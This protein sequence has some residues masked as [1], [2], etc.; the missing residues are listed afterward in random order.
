MIT[1][2]KNLYTFFFK[3]QNADKNFLAFFRLS[4]GAFCLLRFLAIRKDFSL[5]YSKEGVIP[6]EVGELYKIKFIPSISDFSDFL[7]NHLGFSEHNALLLFQC[8]YIAAAVFVIIGFIS[9]G[10]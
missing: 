2:M 5:L 7:N 4:I 10:S 8:I 9:R 1:T 6:A 3:Q